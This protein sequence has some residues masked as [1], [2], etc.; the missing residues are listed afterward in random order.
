MQMK[1][2]LLAAGSAMALTVAASPANAAAVISGNGFWGAS[3]PSTAYSA[4]NT[5][6][7]FT[8]QLPNPLDSNPTS[9]ISNFF[10]FLNGSLVGSTPNA[11]QF[12]SIGDMGLFD[13]IFDDATVS[14]YGA[15]IA[16]NGYTPGNFGAEAAINAGNVIGNGS[17]SLSITA[18]PE[19][20]TWVM[21]IG[22][23]GMAGA[24]MRRKNRGVA[25]TRAAA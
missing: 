24:A 2:I 20:A 17:V 6:F 25:L 22:G 3:T 11:V 19:P 23:F 13:L 5:T 18:V 4:P 10:Y 1:K 16:T 15:D 12:Y 14:F 8:F 9:S 21:M 7:A